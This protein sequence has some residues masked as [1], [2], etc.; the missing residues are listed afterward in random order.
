MFAE[1]EE[2]EQN[3]RPRTADVGKPEV[4]YLMQ[5]NWGLHETFK[6]HRLFGVWRSDC[7]LI[8]IRPM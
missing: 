8:H 1:E 7:P 6:F 4:C 5:I 3:N 2:E